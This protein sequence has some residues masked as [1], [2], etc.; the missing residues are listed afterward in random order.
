MWVLSTIS[1]F[2]QVSS[3]SCK[4]SCYFLKVASSCGYVPQV[5]RTH[6]CFAQEASACGFFVQG[7]NVFVSINALAEVDA[8]VEVLSM[9]FTRKSKACFIWNCKL[10]LSAS[11]WGIVFIFYGII[12]RILVLAEF[13]YKFFNYCV[14]S[15]FKIPF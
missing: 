6:G 8:S 10:C 11:Q 9:Q 13:T 4:Y 5:G 7:T 1:K 12:E 14:L 15:S 2:Y 3:T